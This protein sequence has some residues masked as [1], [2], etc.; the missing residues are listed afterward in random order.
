MTAAE[1]ALNIQVYG[2]VIPGDYAVDVRGNWINVNNPSH[3]G[4]IYMDAQSGT[5]SGSWDGGSVVSPRGVYDAS[6]GCEGGSCVN[7]ID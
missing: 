3:R 6:G 7:I 2:G 5:Q 1:C 4:N